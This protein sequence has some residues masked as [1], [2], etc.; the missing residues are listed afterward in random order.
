MRVVL[1]GSA[2]PVAS[3]VIVTYG[4]WRWTA[5]ALAAL[6]DH[7]S[8]PYE[9]ILVDNASPDETP[10]RLRSEVEGATIVFN[11]A[12]LGFGL[13]ANQ[14]A[15]LARGRHLVFLNSDAMVRSGWLEAL[16]G[17][18]DADARVA[19]A[20][21]RYMNV[22]GSVQEAGGLL[23][24]D[25]STLMWG[26]GADP[27]DPAFRFP[28]AVDYGSAA[29]LLVRRWAFEAVGGFDAAFRPMYCEDVDLMLALRARGMRTVYEPRAEVVHVRFGSS[30]QEETTARRLVDANTPILRRR[31]RQVLADRP[32]PFDGEAAARLTASRDADAVPRILVIGRRADAALL[33]ALA[34]RYPGGRVT[35]LGSTATA[36]E[37]EL[38]L[39]RG[40]EVAPE[41]SGAHAW[42]RDRLFQASVVV[43][44][45]SDALA[46][47][48]A[49]LVETQPQ[50]AVI[51]DLTRRADGTEVARAAEDGLRV[52]LT[53]GRGD[54]PRRV[55]LVLEALDR[56]GIAGAPW[57]VGATGSAP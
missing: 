57:P 16:A 2:S 28:R 11:E 3:V 18:V 39:S 6:R 29:C 54:A 23:W 33:E 13:A 8:A 43:V 44:D 36:S 51:A 48:A 12:N 25:G 41:R 17:A 5:E 24:R 45:G 50:A 42:L 15:A 52:D 32:Q 14:G 34:R 1:S 26:H 9:V 20:I 55:A 4:G 56:L 47:V 53:I 21:P 35:F 27:E 38:L 49:A 19:A 30:G 40:V 37:A 7:T 10:E 46:E 31:W 22:D